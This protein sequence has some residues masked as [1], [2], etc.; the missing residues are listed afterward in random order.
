MN[1]PK[2]SRGSNNP[3]PPPSPN[4]RRIAAVIKRSVPSLINLFTIYLTIQWE[5]VE[6]NR[7]GDFLGLNDPGFESR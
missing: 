6:N 2:K 5:P 4:G 7:F 1:N 3:P